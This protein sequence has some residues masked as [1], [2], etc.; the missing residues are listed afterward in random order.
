MSQSPPEIAELDATLRQSRAQYRSL[1]ESMDLGYILVEVIIDTDDRAVDLR[2]LEAN[3][4][5]VKMTGA[6][7]VGR[8]T[9]ELSPDFEQHWFDTFGRVARTGV[10]ER[11]EFTA[12][13]LGV[14]YDFCVFKVGAPETRRVVALYQDIT[15][16]K[17]A[18]A[19]LRDDAVSKAYLLA[20]S[21]AI[22]PLLDP[23]AIQRAA[24]HLLAEH[25]ETARAFYG[26]AHD[27]GTFEVQSEHVRGDAPSVMGTYHLDDFRPVG[28]VLRTGRTYVVDDVLA[29]PDVGRDVGARFESY[30]VRSQVAVPLVKGGRLVA[31]LMVNQPTR[32][33]WTSLEVS[34][35]QE[36]AERTWAAVVRA[37]S[38]GAL[39]EREEQLR[40]AHDQLEVRVRERTLELARVNDALKS[41]LDQRQAADAQIKALLKQMVTIQEEERRRVARDI[42]DQLGQ[43][44]TA[45]RLNLQALELP[46]VLSAPLA[47]PIGRVRQLADELDQTVDLLAWTLRP[48]TLDH[49]GLS[50]ALANLTAGWS[51][52]FG[53]N[54]TYHGGSDDAH[55]RLAPDIETNLYRITQEALHN[56]YK[57]ANASHARVTFEHSDG[58]AALVVEDDGRG[59]DAH[60][61]EP[62]VMTRLGL[63]NMR[64]R[65]ALAGG[66]LNIASREGH[67]TVVSVRIVLAPG[68]LR[69]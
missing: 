57:H 21:D 55:A 8:T 66:Q 9:R 50:D 62:V 56:I 40:R 36:T 46:G 27:D 6:E 29:S 30:A 41:Q 65:A 34:L 23:V 7:L 39:R 61:H 49:L 48:A 31:A 22:R 51:E 33:A 25:L 59:F 4:R 3:A 52:R 47:E 43:Q 5:A 60:T 42:H 10:T 16:R 15:E 58:I 1:V 24:T 45:L 20:L 53:I 37:R 2:Y 44:I 12:S 32:R 35:V 14:W 13:P 69:R 54:A 11:H 26:E 64:E 18:E 17:R 28:E 38:E 67:G 19:T 68:D 63:V